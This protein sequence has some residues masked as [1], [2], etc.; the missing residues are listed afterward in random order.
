[1][2]CAQVTVALGDGPSDGQVPVLAVLVVGTGT[3]VVTEPDTKVLD[4]HRILLLN[5]QPNV[6]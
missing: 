4:L 2:T 3:G 1:M 6:I 5:L